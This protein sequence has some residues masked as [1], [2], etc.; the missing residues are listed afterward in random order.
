M[1]FLRFR[2]I[3]LA[4]KQHQ[5]STFLVNKVASS[6]LSENGEIKLPGLEKLLQKHLEHRLNMKPPSWQKINQIQNGSD[7]AQ[8]TQ[9]KLKETGPGFQPQS[10]SQGL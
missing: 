3:M 7:K 9:R 1:S 8:N 6:L 10:V 2:G 5:I 4:S